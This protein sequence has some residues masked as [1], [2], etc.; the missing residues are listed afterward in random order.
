MRNMD[1]Q[2]DPPKSVPA[3]TL[4]VYEWILGSTALI[5]L[6]IINLAN[7]YQSEKWKTFYCP[8][9]YLPDY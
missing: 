7:M 1:G 2:H 8:N 4:V 6:D 3:G 5:T 9:L